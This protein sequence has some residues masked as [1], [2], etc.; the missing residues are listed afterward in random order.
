MQQLTQVK[1]FQKIGKTVYSLKTCKGR[2]FI[3]PGSIFARVVIGFS[4]QIMFFLGKQ[5]S[6]EDQMNSGHLKLTDM[7]L[8]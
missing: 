5:I 8:S 1:H 3:K 6:E 2:I 7:W 4:S